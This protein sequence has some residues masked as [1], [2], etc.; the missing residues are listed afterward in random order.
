VLHTA[1][2]APNDEDVSWKEI[3]AGNLQAETRATVDGLDGEDLR[4]LVDLLADIAAQFFR[5]AWNDIGGIEA[6]AALK[7]AGV[8]GWKPR[9]ERRG[10]GDVSATMAEKRALHARRQYVDPSDPPF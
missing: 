1:W 6:E 10:L 9:V 4:H 2:P 7:D 5:I 3:I 8:R